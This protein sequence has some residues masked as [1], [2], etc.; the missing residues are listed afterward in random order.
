M[1][2]IL[3]ILKDLQDSGQEATIT[4]HFRMEVGNFQEVT[5]SNNV[6]EQPKTNL[7]ETDSGKNPNRYTTEH[8]RDD[9]HVCYSVSSVVLLP[10]VLEVIAAWLDLPDSVKAGIVAMVKAT[11]PATK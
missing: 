9:A 3:S 7:S 4:G 2:R 5:N 11:A 6:H 1:K 8:G 10:D